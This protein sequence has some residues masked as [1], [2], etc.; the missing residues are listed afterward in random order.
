MEK[1]L[2]IFKKLIPQKIWKFIEPAYHYSLASIGAILYRFPSK[3]IKVV[4]VTGTK[5]KSSVV[6]ILHQI[7]TEAGYKTASMSTICFRLG[8]KVYPNLFKMTMP[9]RFFIQKFIREAVKGNCQFVILEMT[10]EGTKQFRHKFIDLDAL[11]FT[12][13]APEHIESHGGYENYR[14]A[15]LKIA[16]SLAMSSKKKKFMVAN[17]D[18]KEFGLFFDRAKP[19]KPVPFSLKDGEQYLITEDKIIFHFNETEIVAHI[20]G[21]FNL[22]NLLAAAKCAEAFGVKSEK[23]KSAIEKINV[24]P[25]RAETIKSGDIELV[26]DYAHTPDSLKAIYQTFPQKNKICVLGNTGGGRDTWKRP[27]MGEIANSFCT[28]V[29]LTNEDP[30]DEDPNKIVSEM[31]KSISKE[32]LIIEMDRRKAIS[33]AIREASFASNSVVIITGKG[34][35]PYIMEADGKKIPWSDKEV[36]KQELEKFL[37]ERVK[38]AK[39]A[40]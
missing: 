2:R 40:E 6:E 30:Y 24:I 34:T 39:G 15:K 36:A 7:L 26:I 37:V 19:A 8:G 11:I 23:I 18:D 25:G 1:L 13:L 22:Y 29:I 21:L 5:G 33:T 14:E 38:Q 35:D 12:N 20:R 4:G 10:S 16:D 28:K 32:K 3:K 27:I 31:A 9:G 17:A